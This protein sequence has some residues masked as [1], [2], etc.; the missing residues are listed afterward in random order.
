VKSGVLKNDATL[1]NYNRNLP[2]RFQ[3][4]EVVQGKQL[5]ELASF[6]PET[7]ALSPN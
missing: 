7:S 3:H 5:S 1:T 2:E 4:I 6:T